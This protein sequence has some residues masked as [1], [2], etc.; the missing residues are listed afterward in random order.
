V[1]ALDEVIDRIRD[2]AGADFAFVLTQRGRLVTKNA[3]RD[4]PEVGRAKLVGAAQAL[5][6]PGKVGEL[7]MPR[8]DLV[9]FG[10]AA[11]VDV[12]VALAA[13]AIV[14]VVMASWADKRPV[15]PAMDAGLT[16]LEELLA[17]AQAT[18]T[19]APRGA[20]KASARKAAAAKPKAMS[21]LVQ[22]SGPSTSAAAT[23]KKPPTIRVN[24][25]PPVGFSRAAESMPE[26]VIGTATLGRESLAAVELDGQ[27]RGVTASAPDVRVE[28]VSI[29]RDTELDL[30]QEEAK[31]MQSLAGSPIPD[32]LVA[33]AA[34]RLTQPWSEA[35]ADAKRAADA[36]RRGRR[37][38]PPKV[39]MKLEDA[40]DEVIEAL[41]IDDEVLDIAPSAPPKGEPNP[42]RAPNPSIEVWRDAIEKATTLPQAKKKKG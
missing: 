38:A 3:P 13:Q 36:A 41:L 11:P 37:I 30:R 6:G 17:E 42:P 2:D 20:A 14:C 40:D 27:S 32:P 12:F 10:G 26:V 5:G 1:P 33:P 15:L 7:T 16:D 34:H 21:G 25:A 9:R 22:L 39:T 31:R 4:M 19:K 28:L 23:L 29:G 8:A 35:P 24:E 18:R